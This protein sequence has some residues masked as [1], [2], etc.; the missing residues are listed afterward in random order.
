M[1]PA[2]GADDYAAG[3]KYGLAFLQP[4]NARGEFPS[5]LPLVGGMNVKKADPAL[6]EELKRRGVL[7]KAGEITHSDPHCSRCPTPLLYHAQGAWAVK[8]TGSQDG[9]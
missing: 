9:R 5:D 6:I 8:L 2:F 1:A 4:V 7:F 3:Q